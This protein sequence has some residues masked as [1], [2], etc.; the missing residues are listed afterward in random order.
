VVIADD[1]RPARSFLAALLRHNSDV[2]LVGEA[3]DGRAA[4]E[5]IEQLRPDLAML[6]LQMPEVDGLGVARLVRR[7][8]L[9]LLAFVTAYDQYAVQA[10]EANAI[11][12]L[13]KPVE[14]SR[15]RATITRAQERLESADF[16]EAERQRVQRASTAIA[17]APAQSWL[18]RIPARRRDDVIIVPADDLAWAEADGETVR[19]FTVA[20]ERFTLPCRLKDLELRLDP[21][22]FIRL[23]RGVIAQLPL[24]RQVSPGP[25]G[26]SQVMLTNGRKLQ[27]SR[28]RTRVLRDLL[29]KL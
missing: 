3:A 12:Y 26:T 19:L 14:P 20:D 9:P 6:D 4:I 25:G 22:Q 10:F 11:D 1:E 29:L 15:L 27:V 24:I 21:E 28:I 23:S 5:M 8:R 16:R 17:A 7:D 13:L 18:R 2:E